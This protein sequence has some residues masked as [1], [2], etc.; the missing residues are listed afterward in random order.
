MST[1]SKRPA[2][3]TRRQAFGT[4]RVTLMAACAFAF[5]LAFSFNT[6]AAES[7]CNAECERYCFTRF[8]WCGGFFNENC[9]PEYVECAQA[10]GC[11]IGG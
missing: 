7:G 5:G 4:A 10:C 6:S 2:S 9:Y 8:M 3:T 11:D 1:L